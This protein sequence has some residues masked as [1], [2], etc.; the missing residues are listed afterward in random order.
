M[1]YPTHTR[2]YLGFN[3][4]RGI[5]PIR[6]AHLV[7]HCGSLEAAWNASTN[8]LRAAGLDAKTSAALADARQRIDL[9][10]ELARLAQMGIR[11]LTL[12]DADY[13]RLLREAPAAPPLL[14]VRGSL[15]AV[16]EWAVAVVGTRSPTSYGK[17]ATR[18]IVGELAQRGVTIISGLAMGIDSI[19]HQAALDAGGR[20]MAV[21]ACG[22]DVIYPERN[23]AMAQQISEQG[24]LISD[25]P[26][27][28]RPHAA[29][30][31]PRNRIISGL[32]LGV[33]V[34]E[35][36]IKSGALITVEFALEQG[37]DV[38]AVPGHIFSAKS[39]GT[40]RLIRDGAALVGSADDLLE[41]LNLHT[42]Q[43]QQ[44][45]HE[46]APP[47]DPNQAALLR[48]LSAEPQHID[49]IA[50]AC[51]LAA[52]TVAATLTVLELTGWVR[53]VGPMEYVRAR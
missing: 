19:A 15:A 8:D 38:F 29:N 32:S 20:T 25:Y 21:L 1:R 36:G 9:D 46:A 23:R 26:L 10:G 43:I 22:L 44:E 5:G 2:Y 6:Q 4:V 34:V 18:A 28:T 31:P 49:V 48:H 41:A 24:A 47:D 7:E 12:D 11:V 42:A 45:L 53:Q 14:Y 35:A 16:D 50:R 39:H 3:L 51:G 40:H 27:H 33:L 37:R 17:E 30:F 52:P 13:P